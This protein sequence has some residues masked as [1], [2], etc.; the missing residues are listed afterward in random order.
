MVDGVW[1]G[2]QP[3]VIGHFKQ[4]S[5]NKFFDPS[6]PYMRK[7]RDGEENGKKMEK[8]TIMVKIAVHYRRCQ[9][10]A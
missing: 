1:K 6:T 9:S 2:V 10:T 3:Y 5:I 4:L 8:K 7:G